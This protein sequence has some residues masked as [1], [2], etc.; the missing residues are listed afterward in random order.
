MTRFYILYDAVVVAVLAAQ[1]WSLIRVASR[2]PQLTGGWSLF[3]SLAPLT[4]ELGVS[5]LVLVL[6]PASLGV[7]WPTSIQFVPDLSLVLLVVSLI[8]LLTGLLRVG[9]LVQAR[10]LRRSSPEFAMVE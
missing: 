6:Y 10:R 3:G 9:R 5:L 7:S 2:S 4:W 1:V 8:W